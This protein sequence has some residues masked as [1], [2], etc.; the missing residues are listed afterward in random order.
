[1]AD[2]SIAT[3]MYHKSEESGDDSVW[4]CGHYMPSKALAFRSFF[5]SLGAFGNDG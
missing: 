3:R 1:M 2:Q 4:I 5:A